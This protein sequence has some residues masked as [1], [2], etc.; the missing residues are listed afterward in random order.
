M[1]LYTVY[2]YSFCYLFYFIFNLFPDTSYKHRCDGTEVV[3]CL[4]LVLEW[5]TELCSKYVVACICG[6]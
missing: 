4:F 6:Q 5:N 2:I 3:I 1:S